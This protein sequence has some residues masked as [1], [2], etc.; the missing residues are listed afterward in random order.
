VTPFVLCVCKQAAT[1][2]VPLQEACAAT[3]AWALGGHQTLGAMVEDTVERQ[4]AVMGVQL[5]G[6]RQLQGATGTQQV[7]GFGWGRGWM[8]ED[9]DF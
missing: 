1:E 5:E 9:C 8:V 6:G 3:G 2:V 4:P 7:C